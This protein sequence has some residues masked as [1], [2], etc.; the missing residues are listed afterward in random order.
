[1]PR[2][3]LVAFQSIKR[4][5]LFP[6]CHFIKSIVNTIV[7]EAANVDP[8]VQFIPS[9]VLPEKRPLVQFARNQMMKRKRPL[10]TTQTA[11]PEFFP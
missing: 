3:R 11:E 2:E 10:A 8:A 9:I 5:K 7:A 4:I 6:Q 1:M